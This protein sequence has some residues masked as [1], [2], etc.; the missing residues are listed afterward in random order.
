MISVGKGLHASVTLVYV[1]VNV[2]GVTSAV[3]ETVLV[4]VAVLP[5]P[6]TA[7]N[8]LPALLYNRKL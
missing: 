1:P 5:Q 2:G 4:V 3:Q 8:V 7:V 6:S